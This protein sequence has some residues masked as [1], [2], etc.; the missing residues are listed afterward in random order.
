MNLLWYKITD[1]RLRDHEALKKAF[2]KKSDALLVFC[3]DPLFF[4]EIKSSSAINQIKFD[5][6]KEKFLYQSLIDLYDKIKENDGHLNIYLDSPENVIPELVKKYDIKGIYH[7]QDTTKEEI[8]QLEE[9][10]KKLPE[11]TKIK[12]Y[13]GN[14]LYHIDDLPY[15]IEKV[16]DV[17]TF[18]RKS[19]NFVKLREEVNLSLKKLN[20]CVNDT[21]NINVI[22]EKNSQLECAIAFEGG[23]SKAW[24]RLNYYFY[25]KKLLSYY[26]KTR[27]GLLGDDYSSKF[28]PYLAFGNI[29]AKSIQHEIDNYEKTIEKNDSTYWMYF[30]LLWRDFF[31]FSSLKFG[32]KIFHI[33][34][35]KGKKIK[36]REANEE[37][38]NLFNKWKDGQ[39]GYPYIDANMIE[40]KKTGFMS[41]RGRQMVASFLVKD[42]KIDWRLGAEYFESMLIDHDVASNYGNWNYAAGIGADPREDRYF[43]VYKQAYTYDRNCNYI[44]KWIPSLS[45]E[46]KKNIINC[47]ELNDYFDKII[48]I[49]NHY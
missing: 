47:I 41:N 3:L 43:N 25:K 44:L 18:F 32:N 39:T 6:F 27:N 5:K 33:T 42:L 4:Q 9:I 46:I 35:S 7:L 36:W 34:G 40:L 30:E 23:E 37:T 12:S 24:E 28:S 1:L 16:P 26:K 19:L 49:K 14:T 15:K 31:R 45:K 11:E 8:N 10:K 29:S 20:K 22:K 21:D 13:W 38:I 2:S 17:F 48:A